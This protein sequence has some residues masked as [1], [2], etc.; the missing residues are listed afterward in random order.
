MEFY[1]PSIIRKD[2]QS[3]LMSLAFEKFGPGDKSVEFAKLLRDKE[4]NFL[5]FKHYRFF[6][7]PITAFFQAFQALD[8][9]EGDL[10]VLSPF[11]PSLYN[12]L[13]ANLNVDVEF[14]DVEL[15]S[16]QVKAEDVISLGKQKKVKCFFATSRLGY[17]PDLK[18]IK[19]AGIKLFCDVTES[20]GMDIDMEGIDVAFLSLEDDCL[21]TA[22]GGAGIFSESV[23]FDEILREDE[24]CDINVSLA[25]KQLE[26][27]DLFLAKRKEIQKSFVQA[28]NSG[29]NKIF[30]FF[31]EEGRDNACF[32]ALFLENHKEALAFLS[33]KKIPVKRTFSRTIFEEMT[34]KSK[35]INCLS[36]YNKVWSFP[37]YY[38]LKSDEIELIR[39]VIA[40][41]P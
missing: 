4:K 9:K 37:L 35:F 40:V 27:Y 30:S 18:K 36:L 33:K 17:L 12:S 7:S 11:T 24:L 16:G 14:L 39:K 10:V 19:E 38:Y 41:L 25:L 20:L 15:Q 23:N 32:F 34:N 31:A 21:V 2:M 22:A 26:N 3:V 8:V 28:A 1:K 29:K 13:L 6:R 5:S